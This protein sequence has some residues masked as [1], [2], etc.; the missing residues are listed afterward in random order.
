M[1]GRLVI[2]FVGCFLA[3]ALAGCGDGPATA[4]V[5]GEVRVNGAAVDKGVIAYSPADSTG[6]PVTAEIKNGRYEI[7]TTAGPKHVRI[8]VPVVTGK[9]K[10]SLS[11]DATWVDRTA[12][13]LP[14]K[15]HS[16]SELTFDVLPGSNTK[17]WDLNVKRR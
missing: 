17:D 7:H 5:T 14:D 16:R 10:Q 4:T 2:P 3:G 12:E 15:Y 6:A 11:A 9:Q 13:S 8:S 1:I